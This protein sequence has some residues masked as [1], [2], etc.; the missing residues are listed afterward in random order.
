MRHS[1]YLLI[2][3]ERAFAPLR[4]KN[5]RKAKVARAIVAYENSRIASK[6]A[7]NGVVMNEHER[8]GGAARQHFSKGRYQYLPYELKSRITYKEYVN[9]M[10]L[11]KQLNIAWA[12][13]KV[14]TEKSFDTIH[15]WNLESSSIASVFEWN[16]SQMIENEF[17]TL[18]MDYEK[19][20]AT[21]SEPARAYWIEQILKEL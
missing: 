5:S 1:W 13:K 17:A 9:A 10:K 14:K 2:D 20:G 19:V 16:G 8:F 18:M 21:G 4:E 12:F 11:L 15:M 3:I 7:S 6:Q